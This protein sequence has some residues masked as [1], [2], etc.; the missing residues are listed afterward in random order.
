[1][2]GTVADQET[3]EALKTFWDNDPDLKSTFGVLR[4]GRLKPDKDLPAQT[5]VN[6]GQQTV[7]GATEKAPYAKLSATQDPGRFQY[8]APISSGSGYI[9]YGSVTITGY[10]SRSDMVTMAKLLRSKLAWLPRDGLTLQQFFP[11]AYFMVCRPLGEPKLSEDETVK[12]AK[13]V[14][15]CSADYELVTTRFV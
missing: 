6:Q 4:S 7:P 13:D 8:Y 14:W 9:H 1:M 12:D 15:S 11:T 3:L 10:G 5:Q 2:A